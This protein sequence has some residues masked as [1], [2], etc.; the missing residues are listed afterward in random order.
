MK[1]KNLYFYL[2][3]ACTIYSCANMVTPSGGEKDLTPPI[4]LAYSPDTNSLYFDAPEIQIQFNEYVVLNDVFN[5]I[6]ISPPL[7][8][9]PEYKLKGK[10][11]T[12]KL[13]STLKDSTTYTINFGQAIKDNTEGNILNN[14][15]Y[16]FS[17][18]EYLDSLSVAGKV[19]DLL[20]GAPA[21]KTFVVLYYEPSDTSFQTSKPYYFSRTDPEGNFIIKNIRSGDYKLYAIEDQ[22]FNYYY[23]LPNERIAF[24]TDLIHVDSNITNQKL[25]I[26]SEEK[27]KQNLLEAKSKR[28]GQTQLVFSRPST[29]V[30]ITSLNNIPENIYYTK[31]KTL[32]T[33]NIWSDNYRLDTFK[34]KIAYDTTELIRAI[35][36]KAIAID[37]N[38]SLNTNTYTT[39]AVALSKS[40]TALADWDPEKK[41]QIN[42][43]NPILQI[44]T[45]NIKILQ[46]DDSMYV[47]NYSLTIDSLDARKILIASEWKPE[48]K[49][50]IIINKNFTKDIFSLTNKVDTMRLQVRKADTYA[51]LTTTIKNTS[52]HTLVFQLLKYDLTVLQEK[53]LPT[54]FFENAENKYAVKI[55]NLIPGNYR[56]RVIIDLDNNGKWTPGNLERNALP[57]PVILFPVEQNLRANWENAIDWVIN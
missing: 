49:Y 50:D 1:L 57:E 39:N 45:S 38:F 2:I 24:Q 32:D 13:N 36:L 44:D 28:Y 29:D 56:L 12:I 37:S 40:A 5:Q 51:Q 43:Y 53:I 31:N 4:V 47:T 42:F 48:K 26:F 27:I 34:I 14:F 15:T 7:D 30:N 41:I 35:S 3:L 8:G 33:I 17:T 18:G 52:G 19:T 23:D 9:I 25:Q 11:L 21:V 22:N 54:S 20:T 6:I 55:N 16:V 10:T 46:V